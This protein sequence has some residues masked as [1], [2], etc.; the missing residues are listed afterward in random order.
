MI[1]MT[2]LTKTFNC[3]TDYVL[4]QI[5]TV[6]LEQL[7]LFFEHLPTD[8]YLSG[9]YRFRRLSH[10]Q[11]DVDR[12]TKLPHSRLYQSKSYNPV[13]GDVVR[14]Y[15]ELEDQLVGLADFQKIVLEFFDFCQL[16]ST[17]RELGIHQIRTTTS[18]Q[19]IGN[20]APEGIHRDGV[21]LVGIFCVGR[22]NISGGETRLYTSKHEP[23]VF[24][25]ILNPGEFLIFSDRTFFHH[26]SLIQTTSP[27]GGTRDVFVLTCP[28]LLAS[29]H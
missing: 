26:T 18:A 21:D 22:D 3:F 27:K 15:P 6:N 11:V 8:P 23:P 29:K 13:L 14:D 1:M 12:L 4:E 2:E 20:P 24:T 16:C 25:K 10:F 5:N 19:E 7:K 9:H 17:S 28:G